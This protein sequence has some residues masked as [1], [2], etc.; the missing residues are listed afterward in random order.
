MVMIKTQNWLVQEKYD[1]MRIQI[2]KIDNKV[3]IYS[4]NQKDI[5]EKCPEQV[6]I[7]KNKHFGDCVLDAELLLFDGDEPL[8]RAEVV[9]KVFK[10]KESDTELRAHVF[11]I[12]RHE[13]KDMVEDELSERIRTLFQNY[14]QH[15]H[16]KLQFPSKKDTREA[17][18]LKEI[19][20][21]A[22][23]IMKIPTAE[24]VVIKD[25]TSTYYV[26]T[27]K[28]PKWVKWKKF[29][30]LDLIVIGKKST[31]SN[32]FSYTLGAG[33][34]TPEEA[35]KTKSKEIDGKFYMNVGNAVNTNIDVDENSI[36]RVKVDEV[37]RRGDRFSIYSAKVI[38][39]PEVEYPDKVVTLELLAAN[40]KKSI[41]YKVKALEKGI[42][43]TDNIHGEAMVLAKGDM[44]GFTIFGFDEYNLMAK[45]ALVDL[46]SWK[47]EIENI[48][49]MKKGEI[50]TF[51]KNYLHENGPS[52][53]EEI[54][55]GI[56]NSKD[57]YKKLYAQ[58]FDGDVR[59]L[60]KYCI[61]Q[62]AEEPGEK[63]WEYDKQTDKFT[64]NPDMLTKYETPK[65]LRSGQF[66][67]YLRKDGNLN[68]SIKL[69]DKTMIWNIRINSVDDVFNLFGK[70]KKFPAQVEEN[71]DK[72]KLVDEGDITLGVQR[73]GYHEYFLEGNKFESKLH[74]RVVPIEGE[75]YWVAFTSVK[76]KPVEE[77]SDDGIWDI[78]ADKHKKRTFENLKEQ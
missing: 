55:K 15:S 75:D 19:A 62:I 21:Y 73:H 16:E 10:D 61:N 8:Q 51:I 28:N 5:T 44:D 57:K 35:K 38:E 37:N 42:S 13:E 23:E 70:S 67:L 4:Y 22:K 33:P 52:S 18:S 7:M 29:V 53:I 54:A 64:N 49:K 24:G 41:K 48:Y 40:N 47:S 69:E 26:G 58:L 1:G 59:K 9:A 72:T 56:L 45:N 32:M 43:V 14:A 46:D 2:H 36:V 17:D 50:R 71:S 39:I 60:K 20:D 78:Y 11:D 34:I 27:R 77:E 63:Y 74:F 6:K 76:Q 12:M 68:L 65:N 3:K 31:K 66:K 25:I 30:D